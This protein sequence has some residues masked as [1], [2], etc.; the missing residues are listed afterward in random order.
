MSNICDI[1]IKHSER[2]INIKLVYLCL[3]PTERIYLDKIKQ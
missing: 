2:N 1:Y 3:Q